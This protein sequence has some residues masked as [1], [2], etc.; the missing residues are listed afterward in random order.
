MSGECNDCGE[1][2]VDC[3]CSKGRSMTHDD[4]HFLTDFLLLISEYKDRVSEK[5]MATILTTILDRLAERA[6]NLQHN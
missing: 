1:H 4:V 2:A 3:K 5:D 6:K